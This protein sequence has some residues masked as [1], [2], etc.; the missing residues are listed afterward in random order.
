MV[1]AF[2]GLAHPYKANVLRTK[3]DYGIAHMPQVQQTLAD[4]KAS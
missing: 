1:I 2:E 3:G 4:A